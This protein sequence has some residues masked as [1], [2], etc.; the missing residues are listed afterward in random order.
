MNSCRNVDLSDTCTTVTGSNGINCTGLQVVTDFKLIPN[1]TD[2]T[3]E[4]FQANKHECNMNKNVVF[5]WKE[6][7]KGKGI[8]MNR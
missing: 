5:V 3:R 1:T 6:L 8:D 4:W 7:E 2:P